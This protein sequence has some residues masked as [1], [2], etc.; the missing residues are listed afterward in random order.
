MLSDV[1]DGID[2]IVRGS[3]KPLRLRLQVDGVD[4]TPSAVSCSVVDVAG[5]VVASPAATA[6]TTSTATLLGTSTVGRALGDGWAVLW[7]ATV[8]GQSHTFRHAA[9]LCL[10]DIYPVIADADLY[11]RQSS[12]NP[13]SARRLTTR[14]EYTAFRA[15]AWKE[16]HERL[17]ANG[18]RPWLVLEPAT[19]RTPH[20]LLSIALI[21]EDLAATNPEAYLGQAQT[22]RKAFESAFKGL[23]FQY[24][25]DQA[26][27]PTQGQDGLA[28][29]SRARPAVWLTST[30]R[31]VW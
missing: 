9:A 17:L 16:I 11:A 2:T 1:H 6:G 24:D 7:T 23:N 18:R 3:D 27:L 12:L 20:I 10:R 5:N 26:G 8:S 30:D 21:F 15:E 4:V 14:T 25:A 31:G 19:L 28:R 22:Y 29:R 13:S